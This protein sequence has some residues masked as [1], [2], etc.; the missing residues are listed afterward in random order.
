MAAL[1]LNRKSLILTIWMIALSMA[2]TNCSSCSSNSGGMAVAVPNVV[3]DTQAAA[4]TAITGAGLVVGTVTMAS[5]AT[6]AV[7]NVISQMPVAGTSVAG[8]SAVSLTVSSGP[9]MVNVPNVL[10]DTQA[11]ATSAITGAGLTLGTVT[12]ASSATVAAGDVISQMPA[13]GTSVAN[14]SAVNLSVSSG[15]AVN[16]PN[17]VG[18]TQA[19]ATTVITG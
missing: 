19:A 8:G 9:A 4:T 6:V 15:P 16:V 5:S 7:G 13:A 17:V 2:L 10:G 18:D 14:S 3:G 12:M 11:A 1:G